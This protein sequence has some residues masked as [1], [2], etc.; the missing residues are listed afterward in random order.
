MA[1]WEDGSQ[2]AEDIRATQRSGPYAFGEG[3]HPAV[4][5]LNRKLAHTVELRLE[6]HHDGG[7]L[8]KPIAQRI[9]LLTSM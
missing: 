9:D 1:R 7:L 8:P 3:Q 5:I 2:G 4:R 6:W